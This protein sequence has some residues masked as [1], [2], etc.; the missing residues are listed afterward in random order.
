LYCKNSKQYNDALS[1][2]A[3]CLLAKHLFRQLRKVLNPSFG[4]MNSART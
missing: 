4:S 3:S 2:I 1:K